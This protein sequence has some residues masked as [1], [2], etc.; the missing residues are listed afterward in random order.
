MRLA[1]RSRQNG[2]RAP[3]THGRLDRK[4]RR[5]PQARGSRS[6][7]PRWIALAHRGSAEGGTGVRDLHGRAPSIAIS[8]REAFRRR[9]EERQAAR[10]QATR[11]TEGQGREE[12]MNGRFE[13]VS[14]R[15]SI[16]VDI[17]WCA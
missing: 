16:E 13:S 11:E 8:D 15:Q 10:A 1:D 7:R 12:A 17:W 14:R 5:I 4:A 9:R 6:A 3:D 2:A